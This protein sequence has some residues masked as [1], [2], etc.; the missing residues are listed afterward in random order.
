MRSD[1]KTIIIFCIVAIILLTTI[2]VCDHYTARHVLPSDSIAVNDSATR[3]S[4]LTESTA[5]THTL[6]PK[7]FDPNTVS[8][9]EL[10][11]MGLGKFVITSLMRYRAAGGV[12]S[13]KEKFAQIHG[14]TL[15]DYRQLEPYIYISEEFQ[16][17]SDYVSVPRRDYAP[18]AHDTIAQR[19]KL[20]PGQVI[21]LNRSDTTALQ[22]V[23]GIG[24]Y[25]ARQIV[26]LRDRFGGF[27]AVDQLAAIS[28]LPTDCY[29]FFTVDSTAVRKLNINTA[30]FRTLCSHPYIGYDRAKAI[31]DYRQLK[32]PI[33]S[34]QELSLLPGFTPQDQQRLQPY[35]TY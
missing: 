2:F 15:G 35:I 11:A 22:Q 27:I 5:V 3:V 4:S 1:G 6:T 31:S 8:A 13:T 10:Q 19:R 18:S 33:S 28:R 7:P 24:S 30:D 20:A 23:P 12:F 17:A 16:L 9:E 32:G 34:L 21:D 25:Y 26:A 29:A 14:L